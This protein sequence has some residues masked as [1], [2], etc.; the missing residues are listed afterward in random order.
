MTRYEGKSYS[1][2][3]LMLTLIPVT[4]MNKGFFKRLM[5]V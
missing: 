2:L 1:H 3:T 5:R 4:P